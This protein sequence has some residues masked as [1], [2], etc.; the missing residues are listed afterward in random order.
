MTT[1]TRKPKLSLTPSSPSASF[2]S[3][4]NISPSSSSNIVGRSISA[5]RLIYRPTSEVDRE[6][7]EFY[8]GIVRGLYSSLGLPEGAIQDAVASFELRV[9]NSRVKIQPFLSSNSREILKKLSGEINTFVEK[10]AEIERIVFIQSL[11]RR[12]IIFAR[13]KKRGD[14]VL[15]KKRNDFFKALVKDERGYLTNLNSMINGLLNPIKR[16]QKKYDKVIQADIDAIF[17]NIEQISPLHQQLIQKLEIVKTASPWPFIKGIGKV[18][19]SIAE[20]FSVYF[21]YAENIQHAKRTLANVKRN[22]TKSWNL[23]VE[24]KQQIEGDYGN[25]EIENLMNIPTE[26]IKTYANFLE[27]LTEIQFPPDS[28]LGEEHQEIINAYTVIQQ[29]ADAVKKRQEIAY[30]RARINEIQNLLIDNIDL[31]AE[32][33][34]IYTSGKLNESKTK[35]ERNVYLFNDSILL[36]KPDKKSK[37]KVIEF[38]DLAFVQVVESTGIK[39]FDLLTPKSR[40]T[41]L[42]PHGIWIKDLAELIR[43]KKN[44]VFGTPLEEVLEIEG[45]NNGIPIVIEVLTKW[46]EKTNSISELEGLLRIAGRHSL[47]TGLKSALDRAIKP[48]EIDTAIEESMIESGFDVGAVLK[49]Y[50]KELPNPLLTFVLYNELLAIQKNDN[51]K[52]SQRLEQLKE[53]INFKL[54]KHCLPLLKYTMDF[55][56]KIAQNSDRNKMTTQNVAIVMAPNLL[57]PKE[58]TMDSAFDGPHVLATVQQLIEHRDYIFGDSEL[59]LA[60]SM[61]TLSKST[62]ETNKQEQVQVQEQGNQ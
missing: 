29:V 38:A 17:G 47:V 31:H 34:D 46:L 52:S 19:L 5:N 9:V 61:I 33:R 59:I 6:I 2:S 36:T 23:I 51:L 57:R 62:D 1:P 22:K 45:R 7:Y 10:Q 37:F 20:Q 16:N 58:E 50:Y 35:K 60:N 39:G 28:I 41:F 14:F 26:R 32:R 54:P 27:K 15:L 53:I 11:A 42:D 56:A 12:W 3:P 43:K 40:Y 48:E 30:A 25:I 55:L 24:T 44:K 49:T 8:S 18:F 4:L 13:L 21:E